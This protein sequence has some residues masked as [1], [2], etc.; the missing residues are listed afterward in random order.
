MSYVIAFE[1]DGHAKDVTRR[2]T[3]AYNAKTRRSRVDGT[4]GGDKWWK[5][6][7]RM[8][9]TSFQLDRDQIEN[10]ELAKKEAQEPMPKNIQEFKTHPYYALER[11]LRR[12]EVLHPKRQIGKVSA[13]T[14]KPLEPIYRRSDVHQVRSTENWFRLGREVKAGEKPLKI[15][16]PGRKKTGRGPARD[17]VD[18]PFAAHD[19]DDGPNERPGQPMFAAFQTQ[20][21]VPP[22]VS[23]GRVPRNLYGNIDVYT[24]SMVPPGGVWIAHPFA[25]GA[26]K[27]LGVDYA[28][29][30]TG[31]EFKGRTGTAV[32][33]GVV[34]AGEYHEAVSEAIKGFQYAIEEEEV[35]RRSE[36]ALR[37]WKKFLT[38][39]RIRQRI[40]SYADDAGAGSSSG[41]SE[42]AAEEESEG[43]DEG[44]GFL[45]DRDA[46][47]ATEMPQPDQDMQPI[48][49]LD[50]AAPISKALLDAREP[51]VSTW[52]KILPS[53]EEM[54]IKDVEVPLETEEAAGGFLVQDGSA[55][56]AGAG[57]F[58]PDAEAYGGG[59]GGF[60]LENNDASNDDADGAGGGFIVE[61]EEEE[62]P[63]A[64]HTQ[65]KTPPQDIRTKATAEGSATE[66]RCLEPEL[67]KDFPLSVGSSNTGTTG[68][69]VRFPSNDA[70]NAEHATTSP[71]GD[72]AADTDADALAIGG[73]SAAFIAPASD[74]DGAAASAAAAIDRTLAESDEA[75]AE[76]A[77]YAAQESADDAAET[78]SLLS[79][80]PEDEDATPEWLA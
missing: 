8:Y 18:D 13:G 80:D 47:E 79:H 17:E 51:I 27:L 64:P 54:E 4:K 28:D 45:P 21:Y 66:K 32:V 69:A 20:Q 58:L 3:K 11:H 53:E 35:T 34:V 5:R 43:D 10:G 31:F 25:A 16:E 12:N 52:G 68:V 62:E 39:L 30:V 77:D 63:A 67:S 24:N 6:V 26:A 65:H 33:K 41:G 75:Q 37:A 76:A 38:G 9:R 73:A 70:E 44:G 74:T 61:A 48:G 7:M 40:V 42:Y 15:L 57:G 22:P 46:A 59:A 78:S 56:V 19:D 36:M 50:D 72:T 71:A 60:L 55:D 49:D 2:Y 23:N 14:N 29:A 1:E